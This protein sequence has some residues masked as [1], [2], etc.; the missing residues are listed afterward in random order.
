[1]RVAIHQPHYLPWLRY[2]EKVARADVFILL[3]TVAFTK[4][5]W[6]NRNRIKTQNGTVLLT[7]PVHATLG[8]PLSEVR[9]DHN[10]P[11]QKKHWRSIEQAYRKAPFFERYAPGL[12]ALYHADWDRLV[13][14]NHRMLLFF[15]DALGLR[16][17]VYLA[18]SMPV[19]GTGTERLIELVRHVQGDTYYT[20]AFAAETYL[21]AALFEQAGLKL[22]LQ[23]WQAPNYPQ[24]HGEF[25]RDLSI[26]DL[27]MNVGPDSLKILLGESL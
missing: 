10:Q 26:V 12:R 8:M 6:Q 9:I 4:N 11:W 25:V 19:N 5:G 3:D 17:P 2:V 22:E 24:L 23:Q 13:E 21:N 15:L 27:L 20:G 14:L 1:M 18:S 7:V 16:T